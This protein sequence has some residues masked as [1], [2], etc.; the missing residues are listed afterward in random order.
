MSRTSHCSSLAQN[1][2]FPILEVHQLARHL[3]YAVR[4]SSRKAKW[5]LHYFGTR[6]VSLVNQ[7][8]WCHETVDELLIEED[9]DE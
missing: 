8:L 4:R 2:G 6:V 1:D 3:R 5:T 7:V 9:G